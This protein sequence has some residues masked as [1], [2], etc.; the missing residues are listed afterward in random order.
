MTHEGRK[1][2]YRAFSQA[3]SVP[4]LPLRFHC[5]L[6]HPGKPGDPICTPTIFFFPFFFLLLL[7]LFPLLGTSLSLITVTSVYV[8]FVNNTCGYIS[9]DFLLLSLFFFFGNK[10]C[11]SVNPKRIRMIHIFFLFLVC[12]Y[13]YSA[14]RG[15]YWA[16]FI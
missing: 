10:S 1:N 12:L 11:L 14:L 6:L 16:V 15:S 5:E 4:C 8:F 7:L 9:F 3:G 2:Y 13:G